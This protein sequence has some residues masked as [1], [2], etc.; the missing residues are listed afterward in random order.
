MSDEETW[1]EKLDRVRMMSRDERGSKWDL[2]PNDTAA[3]KAVVKR[4]EEDQKTLDA[5]TEVCKRFGFNPDDPERPA[6]GRPPS[7]DLVWEGAFIE[8]RLK[9]LAELESM[10]SPRDPAELL[11]RIRVA[12]DTEALRDLNN[13]L[14]AAHARGFFGAKRQPADVRCEH[15]ADRVRGVGAGVDWC[16]GC[17]SIL[18]MG[19]AIRPDASV[20]DKPAASSPGWYMAARRW[21]AEHD[22]QLLVAGV[23]WEGGGRIEV[24]ACYLSKEGL[25]HRILTVQ[26]VPPKGD[27]A[28][29]RLGVV[30]EKSGG[31]SC[32]CSLTDALVDRLNIKHACCRVHGGSAEF[33]NTPEEHQATMELRATNADAIDILLLNLAGS[34]VQAGNG[35]RALVEDFMRGCTPYRLEHVV[36]DH[37]IRGRRVKLVVRDTEDDI[38]AE[39]VII[40]GPRA[41]V[42]DFLEGRATLGDI[43]QRWS[44]RR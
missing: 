14:G 21:A 26:Y 20:G 39:Q 28:Y 12:D 18:E 44:R 31:L 34:D 8:A 19:A 27:V 29:G 13:E 23:W 4:I 6:D 3:L 24:A 32:Y 16:Q 37:P 7:V 36:D 9:R 25:A 43:E 15:P 17:G 35:E 5:I 22:F 38:I 2:S 40:S 33:F 1:D 11:A 30:D 41:D 10:P 42:D